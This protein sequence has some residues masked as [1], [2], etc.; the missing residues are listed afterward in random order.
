MSFRHSTSSAE[1][2]KNSIHFRGEV[3]RLEAI[4]NERLARVSDLKQSILQKAFS[5]ELTSPPSQ[6]IKEA[7]E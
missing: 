4:Y 3:T 6:A 2:R 7:A 1:L 5:G